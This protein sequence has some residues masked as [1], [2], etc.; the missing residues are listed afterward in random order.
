M[1]VFGWLRMFGNRYEQLAG[2]DLSSKKEHFRGWMEAAL[3]SQ[4]IFVASKDEID[5]MMDD[6]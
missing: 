6:G 4:I 2:D 1:K 5:L 3:D